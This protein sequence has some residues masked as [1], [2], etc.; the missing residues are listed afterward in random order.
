MSFFYPVGLE[1]HENFDHSNH[2]NLFDPTTQSGGFLRLALLIA[3]FNPPTVPDPVHPTWQLASNINHLTV[4][5]VLAQ[6]GYDE[7]DGAGYPGPSGGG[8]QDQGDR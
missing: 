6:T 3:P 5:Q 7:Y 8:G 2:H 1:I 4:A